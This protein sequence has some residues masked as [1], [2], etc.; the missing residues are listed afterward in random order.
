M[1]DL[2]PG[3]VLDSAPQ[4]QSGL[5]DGFILDKPSVLSDVAKSVGIGLAEGG[6]GMLGM[7]GDIRNLASKATDFVGNKLGAAPDKVQQFKD[8]MSVATRF[9]PVGAL[10]NGSTSGELQKGIEKNFT[11]E[12]YKPQTVAGEYARTVGS[13]L[14]AAAI[15]VGGGLPARLLGA[16]FGGLGSE[17]A[18]Q[19]TKGTAAEP[20][21]RVMGGVAGGLVPSAA[22]RII[23]PLPATAERQ[24]LAATMDAEQ[25]PLTAGQRTGS[26]PLQWFESSLGDMPGSGAPTARVMN[27]QAEQFTRAALERTGENA[28][29]ATPP[30][31]DNA[32]NRIG[33]E[34]ERIGRGNNMASDA[35]LGNDLVRVEG[36]YNNLV[37]ASNRAP[38][39]ANTIRDIGDFVAANGGHLTGEQYNAMTSRLARQ[40]RNAAA[41]P[42]LQ[43]ALYGMRRSLDDAMERS[44]FRNNNQADLQALRTARNQYRNLLVVERAATGAGSNAAEG[45]ISPSQLRNA[46]VQQGRMAYARGQGDFADLARSG[47]ALMKPLPQSGTSP[48][49]NVNHIIQTIGAVVGGGAG[50]AGGPAGTAAGALA[51]VAAP[52]L[53]GRVLMSRPVQ[54]YLSNQLAQGVPMNEAFRRALLLSSSQSPRI[55]QQSQAVQ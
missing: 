41:D 38:V 31:I 10:F 19:A 26:R 22:A 18:G 52:A 34:F 12:F 42:Q 48:R 43:E 11:G 3:F 1:S 8:M 7:G 14:P 54:A 25:V 27:N 51:G 24:A 40:A 30:V 23:T 44:L 39:V 35:R 20:Y 4:V 16:V 55:T 45:L 33:N 28:T 49:H 17:A 53:A 6:I 15:P 47:E 13:F 46:V 21:S 32:F 2:P 5:P 50:S 29:R 37:G 9:S 36:E